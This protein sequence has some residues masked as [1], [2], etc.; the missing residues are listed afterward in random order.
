[1]LKSNIQILEKK[2]RIESCEQ[3]E[4]FTTNNNDIE[5]K[6]SIPFSDRYERINTFNLWKINKPDIISLVD[7]GFYY[8]KDDD[9]VICYMCG[10]GLK[11]FKGNVDPVTEHIRYSKKCP[12]LEIIAGGIDNLKKIQKSIKINNYNNK[13]MCY[14][15][16]N[17]KCGDL[18]LCEV[19]KN[20]T[21]NKKSYMGFV[22]LNISNIKNINYTTFESREN[23]Y[24][25]DICNFL[26]FLN[27]TKLSEAGLYYSGVEDLVYC[28][29]CGIGIYNWKDTS[30]PLK[31]HIIHND[32]CKY[33]LK[34]RAEIK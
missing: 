20:I 8:T 19:G 3:S 10:L 32:K 31:N 13:K 23:T 2:N 16:K 28:F 18:V 9:L 5:I 7:A 24:Y 17:I 27:K 30:L 34:V 21:D 6:N 11:N 33:C 29:S 26:L 25:S 12:I 15:V 22:V 1:M 4:N 14:N